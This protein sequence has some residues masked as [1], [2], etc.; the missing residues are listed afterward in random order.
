MTE[1]KT[2]CK[3]HEGLIA[4]TCP[5]CIAVRKLEESK[6]RIKEKK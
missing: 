4:L 1:L 6:A 5:K 2:C 3:E